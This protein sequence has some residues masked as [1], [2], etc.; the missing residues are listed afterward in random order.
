MGSREIHAAMP[1]ITRQEMFGCLQRMVARGIIIRHGTRPHTY[2]LGRPLLPQNR[3]S[4]PGMS[5]AEKIREQLKIRQMAPAEIAQAIGITTERCYQGLRDMLGTYV[6][7]MGDGTY[8]WLRDPKKAMTDEEKNAK[9]RARKKTEAPKVS[10]AI[11]QRPI[12]IRRAP[13][14]S[15]EG[16]RQSV[17]EWLAAGGVIDR[18]PTQSRFERLTAS[19]IGG[20][21]WRGRPMMPNRASRNYLA[22]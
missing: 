6:A 21:D 3:G 11:R 9:R 17:E 16:P 7:K 15:Y 5:T 10:Q 1:D 12:Q 19:D 20:A 18:S 13:V 14:A 2:T 22:G 4:K 8:M